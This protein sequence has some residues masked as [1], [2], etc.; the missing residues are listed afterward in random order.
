MR[1]SRS[2][3]G[4]FI[5][6]KRNIPK[7]LAKELKTK[8]KGIVGISTTTDPYQPFEKKYKLTRYCL[9]QLLKHDFPVSILTKSPLVIRDL[10]LFVNFK[11]I[12]VGITIT[13]IDDSQRRIIEPGAPT[14]DSRIKALKEI[15]FE[16]VETYAFIGPL[17]PTMKEE[18][19]EVL[20]GKIKDAGV[21]R[22]SSDTLNLKPGIWNS[23]SEALKNEP[24]R[25][26]IWKES[27]YGNKKN[28]QDIF[29]YLDNICKKEGIIFEFQRY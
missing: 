23:I 22:L 12:E 21:P 15:S 18:D 24:E 2:K 29:S 17:Y 4:S 10:D 28:Y 1:I 6:V 25:E 5:D 27:V 9:E 19:L 7:V 13:T 3:W 26:K 16:G 20:V 8:K 11:E 14:I